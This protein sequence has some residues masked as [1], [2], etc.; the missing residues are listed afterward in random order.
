MVSY[1]L[2]MMTS[3]AIVC[4]VW[5]MPPMHQKVCT[6]QPHCGESR[7]QLNYI[8]FVISHFIIPKWQEGEDAI[9]FANRVKSAIA[10]QGGLV[11]LQW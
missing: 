7:R 5:Y 9:Q 8:S 4:D 1:L 10:H 2:R 11:D 6:M 3:W